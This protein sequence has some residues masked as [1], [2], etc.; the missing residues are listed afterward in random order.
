M[1]IITFTAIPANAACQSS[2]DNTSDSAVAGNSTE[3][4]QVTGASDPTA[5]TMNPTAATAHNTEDG[6]TG[7]AHIPPAVEQRRL[8]GYSCHVRQLQVRSGTHQVN[9]SVQDKNECN[10][11]NQQLLHTASAERCVA[12]V[13]RELALGLKSAASSRPWGRNRTVAPD[14]A[15]CG[16]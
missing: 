11:G 10:G 5:P 3:R 12:I 4:H 16:S 9:Q 14:Y 7:V 2:A 13:A 6:D 1:R 15:A 8:V